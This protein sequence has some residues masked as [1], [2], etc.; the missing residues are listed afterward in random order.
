MASYAD[1]VS[2]IRGLNY[3]QRQQLGTE[4]KASASKLNQADWVIQELNAGN[5]PGMGAGGSSGTNLLTSLGGKLP[6]GNQT[7]LGGTSG[8][9]PPLGGGTNDPAVTL[10]QFILDALTKM[11]QPASSPNTPTA[12]QTNPFDKMEKLLESIDKKLDSGGILS[13]G[14][15]PSAGNAAVPAAATGGLARIGFIGKALNAI[16]D[17]IEKWGDKGKPPEIPRALPIPQ[18]TFMG[19]P[20]ANQ[21]SHA[22]APVAQAVPEPKDNSNK[23]RMDKLA[24]VVGGF[25]DF[26]SGLNN[27]SEIMNQDKEEQG[28]TKGK[29]KMGAGRMLKGLNNHS[30]MD[31]AADFVSGIGDVAGAIPVVGKPIDAVLKFGAGLLNSVDNLRNWTESLHESNMQ[32]AEFSA[33]MSRVQA[34]QE[35]RDV[36][37]RMEQGE[38]R[39]VSA[40]ELAEAKSR[41][42]RMLAPLEDWSANVKNKIGSVV[43]NSVTAWGNLLKNFY[44]KKKISTDDD[45]DDNP[46][47]SKWGAKKFLFDMGDDWE[48]DYE[49]P[50]R[51]Q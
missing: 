29:F 43:S 39:A 44:D 20:V 15:S 37:L 7:T 46:D 48:K 41:L 23:A 32:F 18:T 12:G 16:E 51:F 28:T 50:G 36:Q 38:R 24:G 8:S 33:S 5:K 47:T 35:S 14:K 42:N 19:M 6:G 9:A 25:N 30:E 26:L 27:P 21:P 4:W 11:S 10:L 22:N 40:Q 49:K 17:R 34:D 45:D 2:Y 1:A 31:G 3:S 13:S